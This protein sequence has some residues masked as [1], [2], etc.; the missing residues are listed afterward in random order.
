ME[1]LNYCLSD[2][3]HGP[4]SVFSRSVC[5]FR[6]GVAQRKVQGHFAVS[7]AKMA[8][9]IEMPFVFW[10]RMGPWKYYYKCFN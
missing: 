9:L 2:T 1:R 6:G 7:Y 10:D 8:E 4:S 3:V 5:L